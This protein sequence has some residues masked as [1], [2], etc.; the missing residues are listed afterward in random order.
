M[1]ND[2]IDK[3]SVEKKFIK[4]LENLEQNLDKVQLAISS[5]NNYLQKNSY[6]LI[7]SLMT[8]KDK[9]EKILFNELLNT[10]FQLEIKCQGSSFYFLKA[11]LSFA[12]EYSKKDNIKNVL[13][14]YLFFL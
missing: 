9:A 13:I 4:S 8:G 12:K 2:F 6:Q 11:F 7:A 5:D 14:F 3:N 1:Y 10:C